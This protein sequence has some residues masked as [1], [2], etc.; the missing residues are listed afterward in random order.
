MSAFSDSS[1]VYYAAYR[2]YS[3]ATSLLH[4]F[5]FF[6]V[7]TG[8]RILHSI[9]KSIWSCLYAAKQITPATTYTLKIGTQTQQL[10]QKTTLHLTLLSTFIRCTSF[11]WERETR[12]Q[13]ILTRAKLSAVLSAS[14][15]RA[16]DDMRD[17]VQL[18]SP[19]FNGEIINRPRNE[20]QCLTAFFGAFGSEGVCIVP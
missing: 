20:K 8:L 13:A 6:M 18:F 1:V 12:Q 14:T 9:N 5:N 10:R 17:V 19:V 3:N 4:A 16:C 11:S 7:F 2:T 15:R